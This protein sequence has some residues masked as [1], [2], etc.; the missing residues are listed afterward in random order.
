M[1]KAILSA[2]S[3]ALLVLSF[4]LLRASHAKPATSGQDNA[5]DKYQVKIDNFIFAPQTL[6]VP[7]GTAGTW[8]GQ[9]D[10]PHNV[11]SSEGKILKSPVLDSGQKFSFT[12]PKRA[13]TL[14]T[15]VSTRR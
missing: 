14:T 11:V 8:V 9:D 13:P 1:K 10:A 12:L 2:T 6:T 7:V 5:S 3:A 4:G 15:A